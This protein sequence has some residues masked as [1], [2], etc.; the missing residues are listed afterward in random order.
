MCIVEAHESTRQRLELSLPKDHEDLIAGKG[1][2]LMSHYN[3]VH[4]F[5][6]ML[7]AMKNPDAKAA[8]DKEWETIPAWLLDI[9]KSKKEVV[10]EAQ[11]DKTK[12][13]IATLMDICHLNKCGGGTK[14]SEV[15]RKNRA[16]R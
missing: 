6:P 5:I 10:L 12:V 8:V 1:Y 3:L 14:I 4:K 9:V 2:N 15:Q 7:Q 11:R 13:H 16:P